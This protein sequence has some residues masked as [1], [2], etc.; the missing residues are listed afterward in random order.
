[1]LVFVKPYSGRILKIILP[2]DHSSKF[3]RETDSVSVLVKSIVKVIVSILF[4]RVYHLLL[5]IL[6][7]YYNY[8]HLSTP[9]STNSGKKA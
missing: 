6:L 5:V 3:S 2:F 1:M 8:R 7:V 4:S 9:F